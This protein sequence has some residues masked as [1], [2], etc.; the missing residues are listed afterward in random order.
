[1]KTDISRRKLFTTTGAAAAGLVGVSILSGCDN[2][3]EQTHG[4]EQAKGFAHKA[5]GGN[6]W[7]ECKCVQI[8]DS[9]TWYDGHDNPK[10][11]HV[12]GYASYLKA[13]FK[14]VDNYAVSG[15]SIAYHKESKYEDVSETVDKID[16]SNYGFCMIAAGQ[17]DLQYQFSPLGSMQDANF[18]KNTFYG[19]YQYILETIYKQNPSIQLMMVTPLKSKK[20][21]ARNFVNKIGLNALDFVKAVKEISARYSIPLL[22]FY[23]IGGFNDYTFDTFTIDGLH[24]NNA[25]FKVLSEKMVAFISQL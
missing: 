5:V 15:A 16:F 12:V 23:E 9:I 17:N 3:S 13:L 4:A 8:G 14:E 11:E 7:K 20:T 18:D 19:G 22:D 10:G 24:P 6:Q 1:M 2:N 25:G 21:N